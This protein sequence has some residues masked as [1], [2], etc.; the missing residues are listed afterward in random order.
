ML[1]DLFGGVCNGS[2]V[3]RLTIENAEHIVLLHCDIIGLELISN[4]LL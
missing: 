1:T 3:E 2:H 4:F